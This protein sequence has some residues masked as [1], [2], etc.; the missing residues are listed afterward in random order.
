MP[1]AEFP[2][3]STEIPP[4]ASLSTETNHRADLTDL[5]EREVEAVSEPE[6]S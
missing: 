3:S 2:V 5:A 4:A 6:R 1:R